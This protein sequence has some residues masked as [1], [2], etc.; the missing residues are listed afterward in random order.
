MSIRFATIGTNFVAQWFAEAALTCPEL[1]YTAVYS[2]N[3]NT[4]REF[5]ACYGAAKIHTDLQ[6]LAEDPEIDAV[7]IASP[8]SLHHQQAI[9]MM[10]HGKHVLCEKAIAS[11]KKELEAM[12]EA[13]RKNHVIL[14]EAM[15]L[16]YDPGLVSIQNAL[17]QIA[18]VRR[19]TLSFGKY[20]S[21]YDKFKEGVIENAFD[22]AFSNGALMDIGVYCVHVLVRLFGAPRHIHAES[23]FLSNGIDG[24]GTILADYEGM[25]TELLYS[26]ISDNLLPS[27]IQGEQGT[28]LID[29]LTSPRKISLI[30]RDGTR[31][32]LGFEIKGLNMIYEVREWIRLIQEQ[33]VE[34]PHHA[35]ALMEMELMDEAR[36]Q[37]GIVFPADS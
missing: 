27:H 3:E 36:R 17:K 32:E 2:R 15:R 9:L 1:T 10:N 20:S 7:Y 18:P 22:P 4:A 30:H 26:K 21:R 28:I 34:H 13:A 14:L 33:Q 11:N 24:A 31:E 25:Q 5:A 12:I 16:A 19:A 29:L 23:L 37:C 6:E 35:Y 8:N